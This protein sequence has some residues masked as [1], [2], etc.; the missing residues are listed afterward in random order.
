M[1]FLKKNFNNLIYAI[2]LLVIGILCI[3]ADASN[4]LSTSADAFRGI[5]LTVGIVLIAVSALALILCVVASVLAKRSVLLGGLASAALLGLGIYF[6]VNDT[7]AGDLIL[8]FIALV[9]YLLLC[10][11]AL[12]VLHGLFDIVFGIVGKNVKGVLL[13]SI[14]AIL[15][16]AVTM[17][18]GFLTIGND[19]VIQKQLMIFGIIVILMAILEVVSCF[20][21]ISVTAFVK[22]EEQDS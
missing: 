22:Q 15:I 1:T 16:G 20:T 12:I 2:V 11:G 8:A 21:V 19:P 14:I 18:L 5:S 13:P 6:I 7:I 3:I 10:I 17:T 4:D 9:P